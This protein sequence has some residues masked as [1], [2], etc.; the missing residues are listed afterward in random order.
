MTPARRGRGPRVGC[1]GRD[2]RG[3]IVDAVA[4]QVAATPDAPAL[5]FE[6][7]NVSTRSSGHV[8]TLARELISYGGSDSA[9][10]L[11]IPRS[12]E[13]IVAIHAIVAAGGQYV[14]I[15]LGTPAD[16][17]EYMLETAG[18]DLFLVTDMSALETPQA[19]DVRTIVVSCDGEADLTTTGHRRRTRR[20][21]PPR[22]GD[23]HAVHLGFHRQAEGRDAAA[24]RCREPPVVGPGRTADRRCRHRDPQD[25]VHL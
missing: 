3:S 2:S 9:V 6:G 11:C 12:V 7:R 8:N 22:R 25:P 13:L 1:R 16:R 20:P 24:R 10:A 15:G 14:P 23:L 17:V 4:A 19:G 18:V 21:D 5:W